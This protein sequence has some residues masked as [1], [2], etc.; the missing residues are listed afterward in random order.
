ML[1]EEQ[2]RQV[3]FERERGISEIRVTPEIAYLFVSVPASEDPAPHR[4][5]VLE[6]MR[7]EEI[8]LFLIKIQPS[9]ISFGIALSNV[10]KARARIEELGYGLVLRENRVMVSVFAQNMREMFGVM[11]TLAETLYQAGAPIEQI[12]DAHDRVICLIDAERAPTAVDR[13][14]KA[15]GLSEF[16]IKWGSKRG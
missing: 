5:R 13:L 2:P 12:G 15:F 4:M 11:A 3:S 16:A 9:G 6:A 7:Q 10:E 8:S 1:P 14:R